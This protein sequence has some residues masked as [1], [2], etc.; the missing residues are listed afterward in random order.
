MFTILEAMNL[1]RSRG[2]SSAELRPL[3]ERLL[4]PSPQ[5][6]CLALRKLSEVLFKLSF[7]LPTLLRPDGIHVIIMRL[8]TRS[9]IPAQ[10]KENFGWIST[11][12][13][14]V[15]NTFFEVLRLLL[16]IA[17]GARGGFW[18]G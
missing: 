8:R 16:A 17:T 2:E 13:L 6:I 18:R 12:C 1:S 14:R 5:L 15:P 4:K 10:N 3:S 11:R 7:T 9:V